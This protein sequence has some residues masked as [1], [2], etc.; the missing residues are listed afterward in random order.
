MKTGM[1]AILLAA[2]L[3]TALAGATAASADTA[4]QKHHPRREEVNARLAN[5]SRRVTTERREGEMGKPKA[6][7]VRSQDRSIRM[8][9][10][11]YASK[12]HGHLTRAEQRKLN[13]EE[14]KVSREIGR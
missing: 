11:L 10:R 12:H 4:W 2:G 14:G 7:Y 9:E 8:Q 3:A 13:R 1:K 6:M 5:Q